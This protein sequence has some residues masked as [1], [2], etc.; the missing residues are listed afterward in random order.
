M[1]KLL[2]TSIAV[3]ALTVS[4]FAQPGAIDL[5]FNP[6]DLG[7]GNGDGADNG[8]YTTS[9]QSDGRIIIGGDFSTY[10]GT[11]RN[12][13]ARINADGT[14]DATFNPVTDRKSVV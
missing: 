5:T 13:I 7:F 3:I 10:N 1:K 14:L 12:R 6:G 2:T 4:I 11:A 9:I 8:V